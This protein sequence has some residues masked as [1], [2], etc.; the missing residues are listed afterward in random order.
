MAISQVCLIP[1]N[2]HIVEEKNIAFG[3]MKVM[4]KKHG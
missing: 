1:Q 4:S 2:D 3:M